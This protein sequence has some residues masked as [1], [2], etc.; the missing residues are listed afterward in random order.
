[1]TGSRVTQEIGTKTTFIKENNQ[2]ALE[3]LRT[4]LRKS[5][6]TNRNTGTLT[7]IVK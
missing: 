1:M 3:D 7:L 6:A 4:G 2:Q 5:L